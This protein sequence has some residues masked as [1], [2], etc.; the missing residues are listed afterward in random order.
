M[1]YYTLYKDFNTDNITTECF[2][3]SRLFFVHKKVQ[4]CATQRSSNRFLLSKNEG[5][6]CPL[7]WANLHRHGASW[8][9]CH[10]VTYEPNC[11]SC[12]SSFAIY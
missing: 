7:P 12:N 4:N 3:F 9:P 8:S 11:E 10:Q 2:L 5:P 6:T 1:H